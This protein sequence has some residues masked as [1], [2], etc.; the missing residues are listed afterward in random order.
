MAKNILVKPLISEK[1]EMLSENHNQVTF[2]VD[3]KANKLE[4][5]KEVERLYNVTVLDVKTLVMPA[6]ERTRYT[7]TGLQKGRTS[8]VKKAIVALD[9]EDEIDFFGEM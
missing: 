5:K 9:A 7:K 6:K 2:L 1:A 3:K 8:V 4:I